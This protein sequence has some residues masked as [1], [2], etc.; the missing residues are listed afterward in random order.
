MH[1]SEP[2]ARAI[3][4]AV[5]GHLLALH[6]SVT[7]FGVHLDGDGFWFTAKLNGM[8]V[9]CRCARQSYQAKAVAADMLHAVLSRAA[10]PEGT[11]ETCLI[12]PS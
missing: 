6:A 1:L 5:V 10:E 7:E 8:D 3:A 11:N 9:H 12:L 4:N 2:E